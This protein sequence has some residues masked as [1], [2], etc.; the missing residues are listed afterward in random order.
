MMLFEPA[1]GQM[2][3]NETYLYVNDGLTAWN[4][5]DAGTLHFYLPAGAN[6]KVEVK[7]TAPDGA[8]IGAPVS[9]Y[10][11]DDIYKV[12][13]P[14]KP[15][16]TRFDVTYTVPYAIGTSY[17]GRVATKDDNTYLI[18]PNG[19]TLKGDHLN[20]LG[21]EPRTQAHVFGLTGASSYKIELTG[22]EIAGSAA[23]PDGS[24]APADQDSFPQPEAIM[25]RINGAIA[26]VLAIA[27]G[28]L[29]LGFALL[30]RKDTHER[31][32]R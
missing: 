29:G 5:P 18:A 28:I 6:G 3:I 12:D 9:K 30:Y 31:G 27:F 23:A 21:Q 1:G 20:D 17:E 32:R 25:P 19:I 11:R 7:G 24:G 4:N 26:P 22:V 10:S 2:E 15:G 14:V 8:A 16:E 13:F